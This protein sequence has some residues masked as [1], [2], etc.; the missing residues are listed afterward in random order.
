MFGSGVRNVEILYRPGK[1]NAR[2]DALSR[3]PVHG[4]AAPESENV[5]VAAV[6]SEERS[7]A[8]L[9]RPHLQSVFPALSTWSS[10]KIQSCES[11]DCVWRVASYPRMNVRPGPWLHGHG[12][13]W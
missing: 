10:R 9:L 12:I 7:V 11:S 6:S 13:S 8:E 1:E 4:E 2:A 5:Q 3:N